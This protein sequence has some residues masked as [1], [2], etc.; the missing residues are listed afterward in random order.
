[1]KE[2]ESG[3]SGAGAGVGGQVSWGERPTAFG[4]PVDFTSSQ[5]AFLKQIFNSNAHWQSLE[6]LGSAMALHLLASTWQEIREP[7]LQAGVS[8]ITGI[9]FDGIGVGLGAFGAFAFLV[10]LKTMM[11]VRVW[12]TLGIHCRPLLK[13]RTPLIVVP[14]LLQLMLPPTSVCHNK[15]VSPPLGSNMLLKA[16]SVPGYQESRFSVLLIGLTLSQ[17]SL[18]SK[19]Q[20]SYFWNPN[21]GFVSSNLSLVRTNIGLFTSDPAVVNL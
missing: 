7:R 21:F 20:V 5:L 9:G 12:L 6:R 14:F 11:F 10:Y 18:L 15:Q 1:M 4:Q 13:Q 2:V 3:I 17:D 19:V 8:F 16:L